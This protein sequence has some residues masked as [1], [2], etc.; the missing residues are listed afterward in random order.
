M[1]DNPLH[2]RRAGVLLHPTSLPSGTLNSDAEKWLDWMHD[3]HLQIWQMLPLSIPD[4]HGSPYQSSSAFAMNPKL[5]ETVPKKPQINPKGF[6]QFIEQQAS[7]ISD[8]A[9][10]TVL[11]ENF[12][13]APWHEWPDEFLNRNETDLNK[14]HADHVDEIDYI[15]WQQYCIFQRWQEIHQYARQR[16]IYLFGDMPIFV[17]YD[18]ADVWANPSEFLLDNELKPLYVAGVPPDYFSETGQ[19]WGNPH[20]N[21]KIMQTE[22]FSWWINRMKHSFDCFDIIR[23]D[24]FR[25]LEAC[26]MIEADAET[27][28]DGFWQ[29]M[30]GAELLDTLHKHF[31]APAIVAEDLGVITPEVRALK[32]KYELPGMSILQ[33]A[34]DAFDDNPHKP[35]NI[36]I[37]NVVY[38]G[39]HDNDT[40][41]GWFDALQKHEKDF[42]YDILESEPRAD[43]AHCL[44]ETALYTKANTAII[45]L[46]DILQLPTEHRMNTP[47]QKE[48][49]WCWK[50]QWDQLDKNICEFLTHHIDTSERHHAG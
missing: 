34:F 46:Q 17:A 42:V 16:N 38:T 40:T 6:A 22:G 14:F 48:N 39:T 35:A 5:L 28:I 20:Y 23:I 21:W 8:F 13:D 49:N 27:A 33:F 15:L 41:V 45:P 19:R 31:N 30:P 29:K 4:H 11:K 32:D 44:I 50:F 10:F 25:G 2:Q 1:T 37:N 18:S 3:C 43:I 7:W 26:W 12:N 9:L 47:G 36:T 24:H